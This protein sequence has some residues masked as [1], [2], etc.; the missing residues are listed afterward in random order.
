ME[1]LVA[2]VDLWVFL[3]V[4]ILGVLSHM[5]YSIAVQEKRRK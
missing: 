3:V 4:Y 2:K 1:T 5:F